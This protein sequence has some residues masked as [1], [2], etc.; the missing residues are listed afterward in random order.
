MQTIDTGVNY[1]IA[2]LSQNK[3]AI[4]TSKYTTNTVIEADFTG[5]L[6]NSQNKINQVNFSLM[7]TIAQIMA[8]S[9]HARSSNLIDLFNLPSVPD[10]RSMTMISDFQKDFYL[11]DGKNSRISQIINKWNF[12]RQTPD[13][14]E[15]V[16]VKIPYLEHATA[17]STT[18]SIK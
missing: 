2:N 3:Q 8:H 15:G 7:T 1:L 18:L 6:L 13:G 14:N 5:N 12:G 9:S 16:E 10:E 17:P 11:P 4:K